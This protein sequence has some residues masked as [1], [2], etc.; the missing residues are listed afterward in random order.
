MIGDQAP[1]SPVKPPPLPRPG[2]ASSF[3]ASVRGLKISENQ[4][5]A[6]QDRVFY[7]FNFFAEV[8]QT[9]N[10]QLGASVD[11]LRV[12]RE[13]LGF[14]KTFNNGNGSFGMELPINTV[15]ANSTILGNFAKVAGTST[16]PG[17]LS[18]FGKYILARDP[19][20]G[21]LVSA[22][23]AISTATGPANFAGAKYLASLDS[24]FIQPFIGY[25]WRRDRFY[26][27]GF[28]ALD[29]PSS[30][31]LATMVF[32]DVGVGY[33]LLQRTDQ[34]AWLT[35]IAPT[36]EV[37][38]NTPL[39]HGDFN[40]RNDPGGVPNVV[41]LTYGINFQFNH[42]SILTLGIVTPVTAPKPFDYEALIQFNVYFGRTRR[43]RPQ[44][45]PMIGG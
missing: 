11:G 41:D 2:Q 26:L 39:T 28:L 31:Q 6:P 14:E 43:E 24:T 36:F 9:L 37:H 42:R 12:Y 27:H 15:S 7:S 4:S 40:N 17:D 34:Q 25:I 1:I 20:S 32:N 10:K 3:V 19:A 21:S 44:N 23:L 22:G 35:A 29:T 38:V 13:I 18:F 8:N 45:A 33:F 5:P 16:A 30:V